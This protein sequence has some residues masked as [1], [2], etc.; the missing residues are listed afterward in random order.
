MTIV[1]LGYVSDTV[2]D[3]IAYRNFL[4]ANLNDYMVPRVIEKIDSVPRT[5]NGKILRK[6]M[7]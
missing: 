7:K 1:A 4:S 5:F 2:L 3:P 6:G